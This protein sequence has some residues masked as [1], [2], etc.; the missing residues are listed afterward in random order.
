MTDTYAV[1]AIRYGHHDRMAAENLLF[2]DDNQTP[3][4]IDYYVWAIVGGERTFILDTGFDPEVAARR[5]RTMV[6]P[7]EQSLPLLGIEPET[8]SDVIISHMHY[9]HAGNLGAFPRA[10]FHLQEAEMQYCTGRCM[11]HKVMRMPFELQD[12]SAM[13]HNLF[14]GRVCYHSGTSQ[15]APGITLHLLGGHS[16]GLQIVE[17][18]TSRGTLVLAS[19]AAHLHANIDQRRPFPVLVDLGD[20]MD[21]LDTLE[22]IATSRDHIIPGHEPRVLS[23]YPR[24]FADLPDIVRLDLTGPK[25]AQG[26]GA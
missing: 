11:C 1:Y 2:S 18:A 8:V 22:R 7:I 3:M 16:G 17:V 25:A 23:D 10:R 6:R 20:Y 15:L 19:D 9:D 4:P 21:G 5:G 24:A 26:A 12:V 14:D 13:V